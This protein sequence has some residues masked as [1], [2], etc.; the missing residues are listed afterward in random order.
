MRAKWSDVIAITMA[1]TCA[2]AAAS[3]VSDA[4]S[5]NRCSRSSRTCSSRVERSRAS[6]VRCR[7]HSRPCSPTWA[8]CNFAWTTSGCL[9]C[10]PQDSF[11]YTRST[12]YERLSMGFFDAL[13]GLPCLHAELKRNSNSQNCR[14]QNRMRVTVTFLGGIALATHFSVAWSVCLS[15][16]CRLSHSCTLLKPFDGIRCQLERTLA[17]SSDTLC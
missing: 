3:W 5:R 17:G 7:A 16:V 10:T 9:Q 15:V 8:G 2:G 13:N 12:L 11:A 14:K 1:T 4:A 6:T